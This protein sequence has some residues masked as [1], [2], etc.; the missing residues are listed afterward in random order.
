MKEVES[1]FEKVN[2]Y[3]KDELNEQAAAHL[4]GCRC[5][6]N[7]DTVNSVILSAVL[8]NGCDKSCVGQTNENANYDAAYADKHWTLG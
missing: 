8:V 7:T 4:C 6:S 1:M 3:L 5:A 2:P